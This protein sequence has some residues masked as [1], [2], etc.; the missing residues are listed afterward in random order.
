MENEDD[1]IVVVLGQDAPADDFDGEV[2]QPESGYL[3]KPSPPALSGVMGDHCIG[4]DTIKMFEAHIASGLLT[5]EQIFSAFCL[6]E[7]GRKLPGYKSPRWHEVM[8]S[9]GLDWHGNP[10]PMEKRV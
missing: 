4:L 6:D 8:A 3:F 5:L 1:F 2:E 9:L 10:L 7:R